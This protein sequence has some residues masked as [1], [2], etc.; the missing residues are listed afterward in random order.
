MC[1]TI[2]VVYAGIS[3]L[4]TTA[5]VTS[6]YDQRIEI[7]FG[8]YESNDKEIDKVYILITKIIEV[9]FYFFSTRLNSY[10]TKWSNDQRTM[11]TPNMGYMYEQTIE[12]M[13]S[14]LYCSEYTYVT[15]LSYTC[16]GLVLV[17][18]IKCAPWRTLI[19]LS[20]NRLLSNQYR[21]GF[22]AL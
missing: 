8:S 22:I 11:F 15:I 4:Y 10:D 17:Q 16:V 18:G 5:R 3:K 1:V 9:L 14:T 13:T 12:R 2:V 21:S 7:C 19:T 6:I 20:R